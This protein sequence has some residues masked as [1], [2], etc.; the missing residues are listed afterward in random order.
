MQTDTAA[1]WAERLNAVGVPAGAVLTVPAILEHPQIRDR[2]MVAEFDAVPGVDR[3]IKVVRTGIKL[4]GQAPSVATPPPT[5]GQ[6][7]RE[8]YGELGIA[9]PEF[10]SL[11]Q[12]GVI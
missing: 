12:Q 8:I 2:G 10:Q 3:D 4:D 6:H 1:A 5:L 11:Q 9:E 7:N